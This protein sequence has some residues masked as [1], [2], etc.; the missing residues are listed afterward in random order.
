[1]KYRVGMA[2]IQNLYPNFPKTQ[3]ERE[4]RGEGKRRERRGVLAPKREGRGE[5]DWHQKVLQRCIFI[6]SKLDARRLLEN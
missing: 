5:G 6:E 3:S 1:M 2:V 4:G